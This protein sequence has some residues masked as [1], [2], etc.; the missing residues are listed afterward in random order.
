MSQPV[1]R[2]TPK[3]PVSPELVSLKMSA[4]QRARVH[5]LASLL[6]DYPDADW[7]A[8][9]GELRGYFADLPSAVRS[10]LEEF[11]SLALEDGEVAWQR[12]YV[13]TFDLKR[14]CS[15][16]LSYYATG[17]TRRRGVALV[18]FLEAYR[19]AGWE[20]DSDDLPDY[21]PAVLEFSALILY[22]AVLSYVGVGVDPSM[23]SFGGMINFARNEMS[24]DPVVWWPFAAAFVFMVTLVLAANLFAD[25]VRDAFD[26]RARAFRARPITHRKKKP[27]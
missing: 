15:L 6:L 14:K 23:N 12:R 17:D 11:V 21:L 7:F 3:R 10:A 19:A 18:T 8:R 27:A 4:V 16:Y 24:R 5:M 25:G 9:L 20:F 26:P 13:A 22:E 2:V 1:A